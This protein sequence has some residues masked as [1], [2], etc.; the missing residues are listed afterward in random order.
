MT[1]LEELGVDRADIHSL[2]EF[3][4]DF[5]DRELDDEAICTLAARAY[6]LGRRSEYKRIKDLFES[7]K[8]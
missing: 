4:Q 3:I 7:S 1:N 6:V 2:H 8:F 5:H